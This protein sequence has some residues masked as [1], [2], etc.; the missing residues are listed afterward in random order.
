MAT[1]TDM[2]AEQ[3]ISLLNLLTSAD[4]SMFTQVKMPRAVRTKPIAA[5]L[6]KGGLPLAQRSSVSAKELPLA[7]ALHCMGTARPPN[8]H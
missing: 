5:A 8:R 6:R 4:P 1:A 2:T 7:W 3:P